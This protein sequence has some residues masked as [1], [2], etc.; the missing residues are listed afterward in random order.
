MKAEILVEHFRLFL[1]WLAAFLCLGTVAEL[2]LTNHTETLIQWIPFALCGLG[3]VTL[4]AVIF[5]P[6]RR[7]I[8]ALRWIMLVTLLGSLFGVYEHGQGNLAFALETN[9]SKANAAPLLSMLIGGNPPLAPGVLAITA[10]V[11]LVATYYHPASSQPV[12]SQVAILQP[13]M[14]S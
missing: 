6:Q 13:V 3:L 11:A 2:M 5:R 7:A 8:L 1:L 14:K 9:A 12:I 10:M 4:L